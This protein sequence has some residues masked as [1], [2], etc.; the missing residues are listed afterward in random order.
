MTGIVI[1]VLLFVGI[2][3]SNN[4]SSNDD[5]YSSNSF[6]NFN[7]RLAGGIKILIVSVSNNL[8]DS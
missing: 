5:L 4:T 1:L 2:V 3:I 7:R 6:V 8:N